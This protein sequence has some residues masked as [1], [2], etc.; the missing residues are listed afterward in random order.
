MCGITGALAFNHQPEDGGSKLQSE[1]DD[2]LD[3]VQHRGP[4]ARGK[5][6]SPDCRVGKDILL[7]LLAKPMANNTSQGS[8]T[9]A[10]P[11]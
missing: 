11:S 4:D 1:I 10:C 5:W 6:V 3:L 8:V 7:G 2:S 9:F